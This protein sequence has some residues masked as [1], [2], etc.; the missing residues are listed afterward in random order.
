MDGTCNVFRV[1]F[2]MFQALRCFRTINSPGTGPAA[3]EIVLD[4]QFH[5]YF[6]NEFW[7]KRQVKFH[8]TIQN[9]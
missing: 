7:G 1:G 3:A 5:H 8:G 9:F 2:G 6:L 4:L